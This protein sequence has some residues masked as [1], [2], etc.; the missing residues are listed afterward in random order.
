MATLKKYNYV[1]IVYLILN[2]PTYFPLNDGL[3]D[4]EDVDHCNIQYDLCIF[5]FLSHCKAFH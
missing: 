5:R 2:I 3:A 1:Y 4:Y